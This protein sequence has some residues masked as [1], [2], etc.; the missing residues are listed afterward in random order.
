[1]Q[2]DTGIDPDEISDDFDGQ[3]HRSRSPGQTRD[4][5][6]FLASVPVYKMLA[7]IVTL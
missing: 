3:G 1:M 4:V 5:S 6:D 7:Y 2:F